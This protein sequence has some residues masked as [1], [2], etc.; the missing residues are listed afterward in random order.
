MVDFV[1][2]IAGFIIFFHLQ[3]VCAHRY[4]EAPHVMVS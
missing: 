1:R 4:P 3:G 2:F